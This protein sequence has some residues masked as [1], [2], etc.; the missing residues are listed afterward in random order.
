MGNPNDAHEAVM[1]AQAARELGVHVGSVIQ[2]G[3]YSDAQQLL[4]D[5]GEPSV[6]PYLAPRF[7]VVGIVVLAGDVVADQIDALGSATVLFSPALTRELASCCAYYSYTALDLVG[8]TRH[9]AGVEAGVSRLL[10]QLY[11][12]TGARTYAGIEATADRAIKPEAIALGAFGG[13]AAVALLLIASQVIGRHLRLEAGDSATLRALGAD[14]AMTV[15]DGVV[16]IAGSGDRWVVAGG[17]RGRCTLAAGAVRARATGLS[18]PGRGVRLDR[19]RRR[20]DGRRAGW[21]D[22]GPRRGPSASSRDST[23]PGRGA[24][25]DRGARRRC[26][27]AADHC[28]HRDPLCPRNPVPGAT[29][30]RCARPSWVQ[31]SR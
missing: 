26:D 5:V 17:P 22:C 10:P 2:V 13:L 15:A 16:G 1:N 31:C 27:R 21:P 12:G 19:P 18:L 8:G 14:P 9:L 23:A 24:P 28:G 29:P 7:K 6:K 4:P 20:G 11:A 30:C 3:F 25:V